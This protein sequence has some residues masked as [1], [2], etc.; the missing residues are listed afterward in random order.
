MSRTVD[1]PEEITLP[2]EGMTCGHCVDAVGRALRAVPGVAE[3][4]VDL[5][6]RRA[7]LRLEPGA[8]LPRGVLID[9][10]AAAGY[11]VPEDGTPPPFPASPP[12]LVQIG[13][14]RTVHPPAPVPDSPPSPP[15][16]TA[17]PLDLD[18]AGMHCGSCVAR[19]ETAL[20]AVPGVRQADVNLVDRRARVIVDPG[21]TLPAIEAAVEAAG[22]HASP[23]FDHAD[24]PA[25]EVAA[26]RAER[27][28]E[29]ASRGRRL[30]VGAALT[31]PLAVLG[32]GPMLVPAWADWAHSRQAALVMLALAT[33]VQLVLGLPYVVG[34]LRR[35]RRL[36]ANMDSLIAL[37]TSAAYLYSLVHLVRGDYHNAHFFFDA[38]LILTLI[39]FGS[40]LEA[41]S[42]GVAGEAIEHLLDLAPRTARRIVNGV[43]EELPLASL[44]I[45]DRVRVRPGETV[46]VDGV[47]VEGESSVDES[48]LTGEPIPVTKRAGDTV[49]G[50]TLNGD[51]TLVVEARRLGRDSALQN[52]VRL[53]REAQASKAGIQ[54]LADRVS[55][56]FVPVVL[57]IALLTLL[58][59]GLLRGRWDEAALNA[60]AVLIIACPCALGLATPMAVAVATGIGARHGLLVRNASVFERFDGLRLVVFDKTGTLTVGHPAVVNVLA[61]EP[62]DRDALLALAGA[63]ERPSEHPLARALAAHAGDAEA[64]GFRAA[65]GRGVSARVGGR[66]VLVGS[67]PWLRDSGVDPAPLLSTASAWERQ[68]RTVLFVAVDARPAGLVA[69]ADQ[70]KPHAREAIETLRRLGVR[71]G[72]LSG[73]NRA[74]AEAVAAEVGI[75]P[76]E[77][78]APVGPDVKLERIEALRREAG[79][80][81]AMVGDGLNDAPALAG[82][83]VG[84]ALGTGT[85]LAKATADVV[86]ATGDLRAVPRAVRLGRATLDAIR[87]NLIWA[88]L[89]NAIGIPVA[90]LGLFGRYG[91][92]VAALAMS[93]SSISVVARSAWLHRVDL[94]GPR[95]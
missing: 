19:V 48:M 88:F 67:E 94:D 60:A 64:E 52:L 5:D 42:R 95:G 78:H 47:V 82:A 75:D 17:S 89:Y 71:V 77:V 72:M 15:P 56:V 8:D 76:N 63:A 59:H 21:V 93:L 12:G 79:G 65:R 11:R 33:V 23:A 36:S 49:T 70:T 22:Y 16:S 53:V 6:A 9:A 4:R 57:V 28:A 80:R 58:G 84:I 38:A 61:L 18:I 73:D 31:V 1:V 54:R 26:L 2:I 7:T 32:L 55:S 92:L 74:T 45:G 66:A 40:W 29:V 51:G 87:Q 20:R 68:A 3:A 81:V 85:D 46:P 44:R 24:D 90:A 35:A 37:G 14:G 39:T 13:L 25:A 10:V 27:A 91:P 50:A 34:A 43:E 83:D 30:L 86:I 69:V 41:R 62:F